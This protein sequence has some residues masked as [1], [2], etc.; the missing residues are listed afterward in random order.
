MTKTPIPLESTLGAREATKQ[1]KDSKDFFASQSK[2]GRS[3][4]VRMNEGIRNLTVSLD[5]RTEA[6]KEIWHERNQ[7]REKKND[8]MDTIDQVIQ[9]A[10]E[11]GATEENERQ[12]IDVLMITQ[13]EAAMR[14]FKKSEAKGRMAIIKHYAGSLTRPS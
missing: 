11:A 3:P 6:L 10:K 12:W 8:K 14:M 1:L 4:A 9:L 13:N 5:N 2:R 7:V